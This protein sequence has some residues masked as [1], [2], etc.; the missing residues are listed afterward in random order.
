MRIVELEKQL[1]EE[2]QRSSQLELLVTD[3]K[4]QSE[5]SKQSIQQQGKIQSEQQVQLHSYEAE[6]SRLKLER[7][8]FT[9]DQENLKRE[10]E[11][12]SKQI[13]QIQSETDNQFNALLGFKKKKKTS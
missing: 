3:L 9:Q 5:L 2:K 4:A 7:E 12:L 1:A 11:K 6:I 13:E 8:Q 10:N